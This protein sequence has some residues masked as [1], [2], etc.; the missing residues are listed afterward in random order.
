MYLHMKFLSQWHE[1]VVRVIWH[2]TALLPQTD[3]LIVS[4]RWCLYAL[5]FGHTGATWRI[6]LNLCF[7]PRKSTTHMAKRSVQPLLYSSRQC[8]QVHWRHLANTTEIVHSGA[9]WQIWLN[10]CILQPTGVHYPN[11]KSI[12]SAV[13]AQF[14]AQSIYTLQQATLTPKMPLLMGDLDPSNS[15]LTV[16][17]QAHY[18]ISITIGS[19]VFAQATVE[20]PYTLQWVPLFPKIAP[21]HTGSGRPSN[22]WFFARIRVHNP[23]GISIGCAVFAQM[24][25]ECPYTLQWDAPFLLSKLPVPIGGSGPPSNTWFSG[26]T[27]V[28]KPNGI[29]IGSAIFARLTSVTDR[30]TNRP[31]YSVGNNRP[32]LRA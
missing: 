10:R 22:T 14:T 1:Q 20:C 13:S 25:A 31:L 17:V 18:P 4:A 30:R 15:W 6:R 19:A 3:G 8:R 24:T 29:S 28:V 16:L 7:S 9:T 2:K 12:G 26:P 27:R 23:N 5:P 32:H 21:S 11:G